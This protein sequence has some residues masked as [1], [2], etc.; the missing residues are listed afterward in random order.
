MGHDKYVTGIN[1]M[2]NVSNQTQRVYPCTY[3]GA[4]TVKST[5]L[6]IKKE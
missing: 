5:I 6:K 4:V 3:R 2:F 1:A